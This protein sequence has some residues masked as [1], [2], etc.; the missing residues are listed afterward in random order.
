MA[1]RLRWDIMRNRNSRRDS[2]V[3]FSMVASRISNSTRM[4]L[5]HL[6]LK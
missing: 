5:S 1:W 4:S 3:V 6:M 2:E